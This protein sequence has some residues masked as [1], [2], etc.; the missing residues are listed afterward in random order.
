MSIDLEELDRAAPSRIWIWFADNGN[1]RKWQTEPFAE[2]TEYLSRAEHDRIIAKQ[3]AARWRE[4]R[5]EF[6]TW[7]RGQGDEVRT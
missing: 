2:G 5:A 7:M 6:E 4:L 1:I 3:A